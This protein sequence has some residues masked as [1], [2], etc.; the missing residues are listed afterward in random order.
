M[1]EKIL[2]LT[3]QKYKRSSDATMNNYKQ[4]TRQPKKIEK[5]LET[6]N[7]LILNQE[8]IENPNRSITSKNN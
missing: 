6:Y 3:P 7:S 4:Q 1:K 5:F 8:E 2:Q